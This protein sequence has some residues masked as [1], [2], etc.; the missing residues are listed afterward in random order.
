[1]TSAAL[2]DLAYLFA[3]LACFAASVRRMDVRGIGYGAVMLS[4]WLV[5]LICVTDLS[6]EWAL[7]PIVSFDAS[8][9]LVVACFL[10][11]ED[12][13]RGWLIFGLFG[14][15]M[16]ALVSMSFR[17]AWGSGICYA[18]LNVIWTTQVLIGGGANVFATLRDWGGR[19][20]DSVGLPYFG[21]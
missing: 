11:R 10:A 21:R 16:V 19:R 6:P 14:V 7:V 4:T 17:G 9:A 20:R 12:D 2:I 15:E 3:G 5:S 1:M 18:V 8:A 13:R